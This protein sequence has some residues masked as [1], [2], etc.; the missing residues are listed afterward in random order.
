M[1]DDLFCVQF[2]AEYTYLDTWKGSIHPDD[3][4]WAEGRM[5]DI[6]TAIKSRFGTTRGK[7]LIK[8]MISQYRSGRV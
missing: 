8:A 1:K 5:E 7:A 4:D 2:A 6:E 3:I